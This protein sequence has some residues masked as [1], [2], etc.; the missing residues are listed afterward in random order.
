MSNGQSINT[1]GIGTGNALAML[2]LRDIQAVAPILFVARNSKGRPIPLHLKGAPGGGKTMVPRLI[3][4]RESQANPGVPF[5]F[6]THNIQISTPADIAG[7]TLFDTRTRLTP[8]AE[9][10]TYTEVQDKVSRFTVPTLFAFNEVFI[11]DSDGNTESY[12]HDDYGQPIY[13]G[14]TVKGIPVAHGI[15]LLDE[16]LQGD[17]EN[18]KACAPMFDEGRVATHYLPPGV[19]VWAA[20]N[21]LA[22]KSG[23][24]KAL[25]FLTNR[26]CGIELRPD[27]AGRSAYFQGRAHLVDSNSEPILPL[28]PLDP[29]TGRANSRIAHHPAVMAFLDQNVDLIDAGVP[30]DPGQPFLS[31]RSLEAMSNI[32]DAM[33]V[34]PDDTPCQWEDDSRRARI[35]SALSAGL[36]GETSAMQFSTTVS[37]FGEIPS[38]AEI[39]A[40]PKNAKVSSKKDAQLVA[41]HMV[42]N[43]VSLSNGEALCAYLK[44]LDDAFY[45]NAI[46]NACMRDGSLLAVPSI[47]AV[48]ANDP[49]AITHMVTA[50]ARGQRREM[51]AA[52][53]R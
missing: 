13:V 33:M 9:P 15:I 50:R 41:S 8:G 30:A 24:G 16:F 4:I 19:A 36:V 6:G 12:T 49:T 17:A 26:E 7:F 14:S 3:A 20:S 52:R 51:G 38:L 46:L 53:R 34:K 5:G 27:P 23:V 44:R 32:F 35:F 11:T 25:A 40:N 43:A 18:R 29:H 28:A 21:R 42:S 2:S 39:A 37:L 47:N 1:S 48:F 22:D 45:K 31:G 10:G